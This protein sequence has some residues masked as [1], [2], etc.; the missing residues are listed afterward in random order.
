MRNYG[1]VAGLII[2]LIVV[3]V[4][5]AAPR[6]DGESP[7]V[8]VAGRLVRAGAAAAPLAAP[9]Q[10]AAAP[11]GVRHWCNA[12]DRPGSWKRP[13]HWARHGAR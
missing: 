9:G 2:M 8:V 11:P 4:A 13:G 10:R 12:Q 5:L 3:V 7:W 6:L 1:A